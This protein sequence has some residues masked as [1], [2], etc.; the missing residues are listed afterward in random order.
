M[1]SSTAA[2]LQCLT[3]E[4]FSNDTVLQPCESD[5]DLCATIAHRDSG[6]MEMSKGIVQSC[7]PSYLCD[8]PFSMSFGAWKLA[9]SVHCCNTDGCNNQHIP[10]PDL[11]AKNGLQCVSCITRGSV[12]NETI[13]CV[14]AQDRCFSTNETVHNSPLSFRGCMST[15]R[16]VTPHL[17]DVSVGGIHL[18]PPGEL[19][20]CGT[21][22]CNSA[23]AIKLSVVPVLLGLISLII[24]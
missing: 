24:Y 9:S 7:L 18:M 12:C 17:R 8:Q 6:G 23:R 1:L 16:C 15:S 13:E 22:F 3:K 4:R 14:G 2:A 5:D 10:Y 21:S 19:K 20:C 11:Q